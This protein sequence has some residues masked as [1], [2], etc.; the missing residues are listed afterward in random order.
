MA[1]LADMDQPVI[2]DPDIDEGAEVDH[3]ADGAHKLHTG[4][5]ILQ[6]QHIRT[7]NRRR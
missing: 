3:I 5:Q 1:Q 6:L 7:Q 2:L 4:R